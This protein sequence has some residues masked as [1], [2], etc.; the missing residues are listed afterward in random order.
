MSF[1]YYWMKVVHLLILYRIR[2]SNPYLTLIIELYNDRFLLFL[3]SLFFLKKG[4]N[5]GKLNHLT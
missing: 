3:I 4:N 5:R 2:I 1:T